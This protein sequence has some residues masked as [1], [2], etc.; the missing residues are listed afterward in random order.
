MSFLNEAI[1][2]SDRF[3]INAIILKDTPID[4]IRGR[5]TIISFF[6]KFLVSQTEDTF[7]EHAETVWLSAKWRLVTDRKSVV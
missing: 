1:N 3:D 4:L 6:E 5:E 7:S 2:N